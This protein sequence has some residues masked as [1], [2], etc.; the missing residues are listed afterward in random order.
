M[1]S[2]NERGTN[3]ES[4]APKSQPVLLAVFDVLGFSARVERE[5]LDTILDSYRRLIDCAV[6]EPDR[7][8]LGAPLTEDGGRVFAIFNLPVRYAYFSDTILLWV[9]LE[10]VFAA[11]FVT[12]CADLMCEALNMGIPLRGAICLG[13]AIMHQGSHTYIGKPLVEAAQLEKGQDWLGLTLG[14]SATW[15]PLMAELDGSSIIEYPIPMKPQLAEF[16]SPIAIDWPRAWR[17]K[18]T[19]CPKERLAALNLD[20]NPL[21]RRK[22]DNATAFVDYSIEHHDWHKHPERIPPDAKLRIVPFEQIQKASA[23]PD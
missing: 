7:R 23:K 15:P 4:E 19:D 22:Y 17:D 11:A 5:S 13:D 8:C 21:V 18:R 9:P 1:S 10:K 6:L 20:Q 2:P 12:R 16:A 3:N 14:W